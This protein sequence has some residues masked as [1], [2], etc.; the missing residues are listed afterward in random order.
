MTKTTSAVRA[1]INVFR[2]SA[3]LFSVL[4]V[5]GAVA[6]GQQFSIKTA[7]GFLF[8]QNS[9]DRSFTI[10]IRG[11]DVKTQQTGENPSFVVD[12]KLVQIVYPSTEDFVPAGKELKDERILE[13][14]QVWESDYLA[15]AFGGKLKL[16]SEAMTVKGT[17]AM[18]WSFVRPKYAEEFDRDLFMTVVVGKH[19]LGLNSPVP[20]E[21]K[22][23]DYAKLHVEIMSTQNVSHKPFD[24]E[25]LAHRHTKGQVG[26]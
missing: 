12:G 6:H 13:L 9:P 21:A 7:D 15:E 4:L 5:L 1:A 26:G 19:I 24:I 20:K 2:R 14:H 17:A 10:E 18:C 22:L 16:T 11:K 3:I 23:D 8:V 25:K